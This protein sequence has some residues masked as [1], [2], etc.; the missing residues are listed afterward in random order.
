VPFVQAGP[1]RLYYREFG[2]GIPATGQHMAL[3]HQDLVFLHGGWGYEVYPFASAIAVLGER[4]RILI[5]DR[6]GYGRSPKLASLPPDFHARAAEETLRFLDALRIERALLWGHSD[7]AVIAALIGLSAPQRCHALILEAFH[8]TRQKHGSL[9]FFRAMIS[10]P[11]IIAARYQEALSSDHGE[12]WQKVLEQNAA[13]WIEIVRSQ[14]GD[15]Y[16]GRLSQ[17][18][19]PALFID[20]SRDPRI[21]PGD[22]ET[23]RR[24]LPQADFRVIEGAGHSPHS[25]PSA[26]GE[27]V[28]IAT[29]W[30]KQQVIGQLTSHN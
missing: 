4:F 2:A 28:R 17:L 5:P 22:P 18:A 24:E 9:D 29:E 11:D 25:E 7:G 20:G 15:L 10:A 16:D 3:P 19:V 13:A 26:A 1:A 6:S 12:A 27:C 14:A 30:C 21:E 8:Y 23:V